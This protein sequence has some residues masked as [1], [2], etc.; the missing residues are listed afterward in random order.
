MII[1][2]SQRI[3][4][5]RSCCDMRRSFDRLARMVVEEL[6]GEP[7]SGDMFVFL[8]RKRT[9]LKALY[10]DKDGYALWYKRLEKGKFNRPLREDCELDRSEWLHMLEGLE[11]RVIGKQ[12]RYNLP[13]DKK[14]K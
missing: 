8:N 7:L 14:F 11:V 3:Y 6:E 9:H 4:V 2:G 5:H 10:W 1:T 13:N 12:P